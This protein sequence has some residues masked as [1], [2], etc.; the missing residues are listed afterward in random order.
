MLFILAR[1]STSE[2]VQFGN[3]CCGVKPCIYVIFLRLEAEWS[4]VVGESAEKLYL[5][6]PS[7][8]IFKCISWCRVRLSRAPIPANVG[9]DKCSRL[10][11]A[12]PGLTFMK[13]GGCCNLAGVSLKIPY[14]AHPQPQFSL[15]LAGAMAWPS[16]IHPKPQLLHM[17]GFV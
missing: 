16:P 15:T 14:Q 11:S 8:L 5:G 1:E 7:D 12:A 6:R 4:S 17:L 2:V 13:T 3:M 10:V 9:M